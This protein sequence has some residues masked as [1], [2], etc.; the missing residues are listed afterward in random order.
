MASYLIS[1]NLRT[2]LTLMAMSSECFNSSMDYAAAKS[3]YGGIVS[4]RY[5]SY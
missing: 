2:V 1:A 4:W 3:A 5:T